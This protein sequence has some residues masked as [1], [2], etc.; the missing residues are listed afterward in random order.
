M[1]S[2]EDDDEIDEEELRES[3]GNF[4]FDGTTGMTWNQFWSSPDANAQYLT[5]R[6][7]RGADT[8]LDEYFVRAGTSAS[9]AEVAEACQQIPAISQ[10]SYRNPRAWKD[11]FETTADRGL[12]MPVYVVPG[13]T[14]ATQLYF[15]RGIARKRW[16]DPQSGTTYLAVQKTNAAADYTMDP[17]S[18]RYASVRKDV[19]AYTLD[20]CRTCVCTLHMKPRAALLDR[21]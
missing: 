5:Q 18:S 13:P 16:T 11:M 1:R 19:K 7:Y 10:Q 8:D 3:I 4:L 21:F 14:F 9:G 17:R 2:L 6:A 15:G 12:F 20:R